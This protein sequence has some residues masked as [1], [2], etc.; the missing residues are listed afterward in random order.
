MKRTTKQL[1]AIG[2]AY[3]R[4]RR[5]KAEKEMKALNINLLFEYQTQWK[6]PNA[7]IRGVKAG[8][9]NTTKLRQRLDKRRKE[10]FAS[11]AS[12][13]HFEELNKVC[14]QLNNLNK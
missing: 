12:S 8:K 3:A 6:T 14:E 5:E 13:W 10:L 7:F 9:L 2:Y 1:N 11:R 4:A